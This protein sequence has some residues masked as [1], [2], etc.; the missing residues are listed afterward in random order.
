M[1]TK[2]TKK[3]RGFVKD[4]LATGNGTEA[5]ANNYAVS[6]DGVAAQIAY[7]NLRKPD[8]QEAIGGA[9]SKESL[10]AK[11]TQLLNQQRI[12]YFVFPKWMEDDEI[13][14]HVEEATGIRVMNVKMTEKGK[15]AFYA[16]ADA[17]IQAKALDLAYKLRGDYAP[18]KSVN[19]NVDVEVDDVI[20]QATIELNEIHRGTSEPSNGEVTSSMGTEAQ[21]KE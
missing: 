3:Q 9:L 8:I 1:K 7:E 12:D 20:K 5:A 11:H 14:D 21:D 15:Y 17:Q 13:V 18:T 19:L 16:I 10:D 6:T 4:Y 2:L